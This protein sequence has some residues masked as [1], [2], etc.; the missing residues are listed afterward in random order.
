MNYY[1]SIDDT[2]IS[3]NVRRL[4]DEK[5]TSSIPSYFKKI[6]FST[7]EEYNSFLDG[8]IPLLNPSL[9][10]KAGK[11]D[12]FSKEISQRDRKIPLIEPTPWGLVSLQKVDVAKDFIQK[13]LVVKQHGI[14]G[15]EYHEHKLEKL[16]VLEGI[17]LIIYAN[18]AA[19]GWK[20]GQMKAR[21][22]AP[23]DIFEFKPY[24][25]HGM[26]ALTDAVIEETSTNYL[27]DLLF[28][29]DS[30]QIITV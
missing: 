12:I 29:F 13:L 11:R 1:F 3:V 20:E 24:D 5:L 25:E 19:S 18:H 26:I 15:F 23:G 9:Q 14:L 21:I 8:L 7:Q 27:D 4:I 28:I 22:A 2:F 17:A 30:Q 10:S 16:K 6:Q